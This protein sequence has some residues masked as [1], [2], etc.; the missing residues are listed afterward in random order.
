VQNPDT[1]RVLA[2][3]KQVTRLVYVFARSLPRSERFALTGQMQRASVSVAANIAE[4]LGRG[5]QG[6]LERFL[7]IARG[8]ASELRVLLELA[9]DLHGVTDDRLLDRV[10]HVG[11]QLTLLIR[12]VATSRSA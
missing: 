1:S 5:S 8:S 12:R 7:R 9:G 3:A 2:N 11:R 4:G 6:D 10:D